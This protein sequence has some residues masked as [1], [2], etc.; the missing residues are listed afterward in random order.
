MQQG[1][2]FQISGSNIQLSTI[3]ARQNIG[4]GTNNPSQKLHIKGNLILNNIDGSYIKTQ[5][6]NLCLQPHQDKFI[7]L[8]GN[9]TLHDSNS[10]SSTNFHSNIF[11]SGFRLSKN[12]FNAWQ[13][14]LDN[15]L[16]RGTLYASVFQKDV[17]R[18]SNGYLF[19]SDAD[20]VVTSSVLQA[21]TS[22]IQSI[23]IKDGYFQPNDLILCKSD[24]SGE[25][26]LNISSYIFQSQGQSTQVWM[27]EQGIIYTSSIQDAVK[28]FELPVRVA[29]H[30]F[31]L[32]VNLNVGD[33]LV[34]IGNTSTASGRKGSLYF[35]ASSNTAP[36]M[37][38]YD[39]VDSVQSFHDPQKQKLR[40]GQLYGIIDQDFGAL[41]GYGLFAKD[42]IYI[43]G[44]INALQGGRIA[45][46]NIN[47][48]S[49][50]K[51]NSASNYSINL[52]SDIPYINVSKYQ[53]FATLG[54]LPYTNSYGFGL[55]KNSNRYFEV[56][57]AS[58]SVTLPDLS[59]ISHNNIYFWLGSPTSYLKW[60]Q[61]S[62]NLH[63]SGTITSSA[64]S[65]GGWIISGSKI[66][67]NDITLDSSGS[68]YIGV[69]NF[70]NTNSSFYVDK[71]G[72]FSLKDKLTFNGDTLS[73][74]GRIQS[75]QGKIANWNILQNSLMSNQTQI[76]SSLQYIRFSNSIYIGKDQTSSKYILQ[77]GNQNNFLKYDGEDLQ[78]TG[79]ITTTQGLIGGWSINSSSLSSNKVN[80]LS[81]TSSNWS[82]QYSLPSP[83]EQITKSFLPF[84]IPHTNSSVSGFNIQLGNIDISQYQGEDFGF[85]INY[86]YYATTS[87]GVY[88][89]SQMELYQKVS[90]IQINKQTLLLQ[91]NLNS[92]GRDKNIGGLYASGYNTSSPLYAR[93]IIRRAD[94][95][96]QYIPYIDQITFSKLHITLGKYQ[97]ITQLSQNGLFVFNNP[98]S[99]IKIGTTNNNKS[100]LD[101]KADQLVVKNLTV[102]QGIFTD[103]IMYGVTQIA[104]TTANTFTINTDYNGSQTQVRFNLNQS[105]KYTFIKSKNQ[106]SF[107]F[108]N[109]AET[110]VTL[111]NVKWGGDDI[112]LNSQV[113]G[114]LQTSH[115][116]LGFNQV[117]KY[118]I[119][120]SYG[121][122]NSITSSN[123]NQL[124]SISGN[125]LTS[126]LNNGLFNISHINYTTSINGT[127]SQ[128]VSNIIVNNGHITHISKSDFDMSHIHYINSMSYGIDQNINIIAPTSSILS[129]SSSDKTV[130][131]DVNPKDLKFGSGISSSKQTYTGHQDV[132]INHKDLQTGSYTSSTTKSDAVICQLFRD[133][134]G[135]VV[136]NK[137][138]NIYGLFSKID[139]IYFNNGAIG[140]NYNSNNLT[141]SGSYLNTIQ[142]IQTTSD[143][144]FKSLTLEGNN[145][146]SKN[147]ITNDFLFNNS[148]N[149][150]SSI[151]LYTSN[152]QVGQYIDQSGNI[153]FYIN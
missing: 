52:N 9:T 5:D 60:D 1:Q 16:V 140:L 77:I 37:T 61:V 18:A 70:N 17:V 30:G 36:Y 141:L 103:A 76:N 72:K 55:Q 96:L 50:T 105:G 92:A 106:T 109:S 129:V 125:S 32:Q 14:E 81:T 134:Y 19:I 147:S 124:I 112:N 100:I 85:N 62:N 8:L 119:L 149:I 146:I 27:D 6:T 122:S 80:I 99:Y 45:G 38:V 23:Y 117:S 79:K 90:D 98:Q 46:W 33:T 66:Y 42:N 28:V 104:G 65:I 150:S 11:G 138:L 114:I 111:S 44:V 139:P 68:I 142:D 102:L 31:G 15:L 41:Q 73:V 49:L 2:G 83:T 21:N 24:N 132:I 84:F 39:G 86:N 78:L 88:L 26:D 95:Q 107:Q 130:I 20:Q 136:S 123:I 67:K 121:S 22:S 47:S 93:I 135:H 97:S 51:V 128:F 152:N 71:Q 116:G 108:G 64:G 133:Q 145:I 118:R 40:I 148:I 29:Q 113:Q 4:V 25:S 48:S 58:N 59:T 34:R 3:F 12:L 120:T 13:L 151:V 115:G 91:R 127:S 75:Y 143:V 89:V 7:R 94:I 137:Y 10:F 54:C 82:N 74:K 57:L 110:R 63:L 43:K 56:A 87:N 153:N 69:G 101:V 126:S 35:D 131:L 144:L 53:T